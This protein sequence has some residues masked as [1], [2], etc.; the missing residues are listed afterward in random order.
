MGRIQQKSKDYRIPVHLTRTLNITNWRYIIVY[1]DVTE[2]QGLD[3][4]T[5]KNQVYFIECISLSEFIKLNLENDSGLY[6]YKFKCN[7]IPC[8][9]C[10]GRGVIDWIDKAVASFEPKEPTSIEYEK[11]KIDKKGQINI[12]EIN[13][14]YLDYKAVSM[15]CSP[16]LVRMYSSTPKIKKGEE[17]CN[18]CF[19]CGVRMP[20]ENHM[21]QATFA[22]P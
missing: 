18:E 12:Y 16:V 9:K 1:E 6:K 21:G 2:K 10:G 7:H 4:C 20:R 15:I 5:N 17:M 13:A 19:G 8:S 11:Y 22:Y 14:P 3:V